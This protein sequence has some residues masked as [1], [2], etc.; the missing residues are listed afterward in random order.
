[1][2]SGRRRPVRMCVKCGAVTDSP[3]AV[4][5]VHVAS[6]PGFTVYACPACAPQP[7]PHDGRLTSGTRVMDTFR[8]KVAVVDGPADPHGWYTLSGEYVDG[9]W[10]AR[11]WTLVPLPPLRGQR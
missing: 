7:A 5:E 11:A 3:I 6:G 4:S 8:M 10:K 1:M 9:S 2:T